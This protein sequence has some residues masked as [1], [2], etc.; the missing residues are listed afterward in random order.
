MLTPSSN[1]ATANPDESASCSATGGGAGSGA[2]ERNLLWLALI[3]V[4]TCLAYFPALRNPFIYDDRHIVLRNNL[5]KDF[6]HSA[7]FFRGVVTSTGSLRVTRPLT[8]LSIALNYRMGG[9][10]PLVYRLTNLL[11]HLGCIVLVWAVLRRLLAAF[12]IGRMAPLCARD[13]DRAALVAAACFALHPINSLAVLMVWKRTTLMATI[14]S[15][16]ALLAL[17]RLRGIGG[18]PAAG[19]R[20]RTALSVATPL[21]VLAATACK[22][23]AVTLPVLTLMIEVWPRPG[24]LPWNRRR[25][26]NVGFLH[27]AQWLVVLPWLTFLFPHYMAGLA[28]VTVWEYLLT[29]AKVIWLYVAMIFH[30]GLLAV[31]YDLAVA[32]SLADGWALVGGVGIIAAFASAIVGVRRVPL[33]GLA[34]VW[35]LLALSPTSSFVPN[36]LLCDEDRCYFAFLL[37]WGLAG[38]GVV[39]LGQASRFRYVAVNALFM[40]ALTAAT[41]TTTMR[42][43]IWND[44]LGVWADALMKYPNSYMAHR[45][46]CAELSSRMDNLKL[47][48]AECRRATL[49]PPPDPGSAISLAKVLLRSGRYPEALQVARAAA[50]GLPQAHEPEQIAG[51]AEWA[52]G[53]PERALAHYRRSLSLKPS[54]D[55]SRLYLAK[56]YQ[57]LGHFTE[58]RLELDRLAASPLLGDPASRALA[59]EI[60]AKLELAPTP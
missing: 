31:S 7:E 30:P 39:R 59:T 26:L 37:L 46:I 23:V 3:G 20:H 6:G 32:H 50:Q 12:P 9:L 34:I 10:D 11:L 48:E 58:A 28:D 4:V 54:D 18:A 25:V 1:V 38:L 15:L 52:Q 49:G 36:T 14:F 27:A 47:A 45:N 22:E 5:I 24:G 43:I 51:H 16:S 21:F 8:M 19:L 13:A 29:Q 53:A 35:V 42:S 44:S 41:V 57:E 55:E 33:I 56:C 2:N 60:R 17:F 40:V